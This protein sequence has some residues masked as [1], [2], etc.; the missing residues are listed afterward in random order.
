[1]NQPS[2]FTPIIISTAIMTVLSVF[3]VLSLINLL[4]CAGIIIGAFAGTSYY[5]KK[6]NEAGSLIQFKD[7]AAIGLFS[8]LL[9]AL[10]VTILNT[11]IMMLSPQNPIP[12]IYKLIDKFGYTLPP[13][14]E[15]MLQKVSGEYSKHGFSI[16]IVGINF[17]MDLIFYPLFGFLGGI[18]ASSVYGKK[19]DA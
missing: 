8:G 12:E 16:T 6:L 14:A 17:L 4:C 7:G 19:K 9:T 1:M 11:L 2:K 3:P 13:E 10:L 18:I 5:A 15:K